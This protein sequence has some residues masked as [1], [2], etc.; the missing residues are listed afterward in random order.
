VRLGVLLVL[1]T[2]IAVAYVAHALTP[3]FTWP[4]AFALAAIV[5]PPDPVAAIAMLRSLGAPAAIESILEGE[6]LVNDATALVAYRL[7]VAAAVTGLFSPWRAAGS[8]ALTG[9]AGVAS[10]LVVGR[11]VVWV[12]GQRGSSRFL[13]ASART[14]GRPSRHAGAGGSALGD[15]RNNIDVMLAHAAGLGQH[16]EQVRGRRRG[17]VEDREVCIEGLCLGN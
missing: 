2:I 16:R 10:G 4:A 17:V 8:L 12:R 11:G 14:V 3:E 15:R 9:V 7:A 13:P 6:G 5:A 1:V